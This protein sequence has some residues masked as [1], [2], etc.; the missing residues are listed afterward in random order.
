MNIVVLAGGLSPER[1]RVLRV[2]RHGGA[3]SAAERAPGGDGGPV[4]GTGGL[5][6]SALGAVPASATAARLSIKEE[7]PDLKAVK[8]A[9]KLRSGSIFGQ[10]VLAACQMADVVFNALHGESGEDG[11]IQAAFDMRGRRLHRLGV[12]GQRHRHG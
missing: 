6:A 8:A 11:R 9:R 3:G 2:G 4:S 12:S 5:S 10:G 1:E 7:E